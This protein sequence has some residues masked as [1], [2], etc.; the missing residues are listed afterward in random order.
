MI[1]KIL[2]ENT[3]PEGSELIDEHGLSIFVETEQTKFIFDCGQSGAAFNNAKLLGVD[4]RGIKF[5][6]LSH[7]HYDHAGGF[8]KLLGVAPI[9]KIY[10]GENFWL[11]KFSRTNDGF[12]YRGCGFDEK[13]LMEFWSWKKIFGW[14]G[15]LSGVT[16]L[17]RYRAN[18]SAEIR[19]IPT[20]LA[21]R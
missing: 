17:R 16:T 3:K 15:I 2:I 11:E 13:F 14:S 5:A 1:L 10:T 7:S 4:L 9:E 18:L 12:K 6:V 21:T 8:P 19:K 20:T